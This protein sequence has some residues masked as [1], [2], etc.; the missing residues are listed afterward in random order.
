[1]IVL[2]L[3]IGA[4]SVLVAAIGVAFHDLVRWLNSRPQEPPHLRGDDS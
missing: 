4:V 3:L 2:S 1:M